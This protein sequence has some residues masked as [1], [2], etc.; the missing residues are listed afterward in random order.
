MGYFIL[1]LYLG[2]WRNN[3][4][5]LEVRLPDLQF[6]SCSSKISR[7][8]LPFGSRKPCKKNNKNKWSRGSRPSNLMEKKLIWESSG[9]RHSNLVGGKNKLGVRTDSI[10]KGLTWI[11]QKSSDILPEIKNSD[12]TSKDDYYPAVFF[13]LLWEEAEPGICKLDLITNKHSSL[14]FVTGYIIASRWHV[15][16]FGVESITWVSSWTEGLLATELTDI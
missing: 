14:R 1:V 6:G 8:R 4:H 15:C 10:I 16:Q 2:A 11:E 13:F 7:L 5:K 9:S 3:S 12:F